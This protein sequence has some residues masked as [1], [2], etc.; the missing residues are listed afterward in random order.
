MVSFTAIDFETAN[1]SPTSICQIG[2]VRVENG[3]VTHKYNQLIQPPNNE[4]NY[5]NT[6]VHGITSENTKHAPIFPE[7]WSDIKD[8]ISGQNVV[9]HN[10]SF[11]STCL[12]KTLKYYNLQKV[13]YKKYCTVKIYK[14]NLAFVC[15]K[16]NIEL[17]HH[18]A[19][20]DANAC[21]QLFLHY[22][23]ESH[24]GNFKLLY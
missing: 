9:A 1:Q 4:Y 10:I 21:A 23:K 8:F 3:E 6:R 18:D 2:L 7:V 11:D 24:L 17:C 12:N 16:Y 19:L 13:E 22:L 5:Y 14:R 15:E 20:S